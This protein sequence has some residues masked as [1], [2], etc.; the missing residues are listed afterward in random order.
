MPIILSENIDNQTT[1]AIWQLTEELPLLFSEINDYLDEAELQYYKKIT[2]INRKK[3]W[4]ATRILLHNEL[5][6]Y[7]KI[8]YDEF[9]KPFITSCKSISISHNKS[10]VAIIFSKN[11]NV[12]I[13]I[14]EISE[15]AKKIKN[16]FLSQEEIKDFSE[17]NSIDNFTLL[18][19]S[20]ETLYKMF[21]KKEL[22]FKEHI[23][24]HNFDIEK[25]TKFLGEV[26]KNGKTIFYNLNYFILNNNIVV[27]CIK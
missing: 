13:D 1:I 10:F 26:K 23:K 7:S 8:Y 5:G 24:I 9:N 18:W 27:W 15:K 22:I 20:K 17:S 25:K 6:R 11:K 16:K 21:G 19:S 14:E 12:G 4:L 2:N 3:E